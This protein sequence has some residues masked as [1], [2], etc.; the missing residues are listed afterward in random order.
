MPIPLAPKRG[1]AR[2][3]TRPASRLFSVQCVFLA[4][5]DS[6]VAGPES[7]RQRWC[8]FSEPLA[9]LRKGIGALF[10]LRLDRV[11]DRR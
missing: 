9:D 11:V 3:I 7:R 6:S 5:F 4:P 10:L 2:F 8:R 1:P